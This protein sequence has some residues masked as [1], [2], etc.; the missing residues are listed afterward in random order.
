[1]VGIRLT[2]ATRLNDV[3]VVAYGTALDVRQA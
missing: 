3:V 1:V 2:L